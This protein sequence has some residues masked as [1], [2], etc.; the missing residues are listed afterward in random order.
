MLLTLLE[1]KRAVVT[2]DAM[3]TQVE[4]A[5]AIIRASADYVMTVKQ[6]PAATAPATD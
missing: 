1:L 4:T 3:H 6:N 2:L 5:R